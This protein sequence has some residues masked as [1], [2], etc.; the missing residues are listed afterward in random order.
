MVTTKDKTKKYILPKSTVP[1]V[2]ENESAT[3][4][5]TQ[6]NKRLLQR[7]TRFKL[8]NQV[9]SALALAALFETPK[10][11]DTPDTTL[12]DGN[13]LYNCL[14]CKIAHLRK[15]KGWLQKDLAKETGISVS[16]ISKLERG[17]QIEGVT[18][19]ILLTLANV[20]EITLKELF[21][22]S[23]EEIAF[24]HYRLKIHNYS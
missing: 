14:G 8:G 21:D 22:F 1:A 10:H 6:T 7:K 18:L 17:Y 4:L 11:S 19:D 9:N 23:K 3:T 16:Y 13:A 2:A 20:L 5:E 12:S 15:I 24:A